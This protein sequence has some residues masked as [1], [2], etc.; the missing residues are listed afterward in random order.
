MTYFTE[1]VPL[2]I[3]VT[4]PVPPA[5]ATEVPVTLHVPPEILSANVETEPR[6]NT[7]GPDMAAT[8]GAAVTVTVWVANA[9]PQ[10]LVKVY[11]IVATPPEIPKMLP[12]ES[13]VNT[14]D[15]EVDHRPP[16]IVSMHM[17]PVPW[18][19]S[20]MPETLPA[21]GSGETVMVLVAVEIPQV[22]V[23]V[24]RR[25]SIPIPAAMAI[26]PLMER[27]DGLEEDQDPPETLS[28][29]VVVD[30]RHTIAGPMMAPESGSRLT[31]K[32]TVTES[33]P[34]TPVV[35]YWMKV[36]P[37][38]SPFTNPVVS[39]MDATAGLAD[40]QTPPLEARMLPGRSQIAFNASE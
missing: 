33:E 18:Q 11:D 16:A 29:N 8:T 23:T 17:E 24:Y 36:E 37:T 30:E 34:Q 10:L 25:V 19:I 6:H 35:L 38:V 40:D 9:A 26:P 5:D 15:E 20:D 22:V 14:D 32:G 1:S 13:T 7:D 27:M 3:G 4:M 31:T 2:L 39:P 12:K 21:V 28:V